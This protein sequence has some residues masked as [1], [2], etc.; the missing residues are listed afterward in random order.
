MVFLEDPPLVEVDP[1]IAPMKSLQQ[2]VCKS[3]NLVGKKTMHEAGL[4][5][6]V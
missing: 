1:N 4:E 6:L 3:L 2:C 5:G